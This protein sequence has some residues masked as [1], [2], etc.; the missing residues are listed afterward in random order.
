MY[1]YL[2]LILSATT[3]YVSIFQIPSSEEASY[4]ILLLQT[5]ADGM[6][7][8]AAAIS[9]YALQEYYDWPHKVLTLHTHVSE[10]HL[11]P[12]KGLQ[13]P[14]VGHPVTIIVTPNVK[15]FQFAVISL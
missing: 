11:A 1:P 7:A 4:P 15:H 10:M 5:I 6:F 14:E 3:V 12:A 8:I 13:V 9:A 2:G